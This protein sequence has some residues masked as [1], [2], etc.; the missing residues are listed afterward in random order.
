[1]ILGSRLAQISRLSPRSSTKLVGYMAVLGFP[2]FLLVSLGGQAGVVGQRAC[3]WHLSS[4]AKWSDMDLH[5]ELH[6]Q[7]LLQQS[8]RSSHQTAPPRS[9]SAVFPEHDAAVPSAISLCVPVCLSGD[10]ARV[11]RC[12]LAGPCRRGRAAAGRGGR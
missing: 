12:G 1:V 8:N 11:E 9:V 4:S 6:F 5:K 10:G 3:S 7:C 2:P